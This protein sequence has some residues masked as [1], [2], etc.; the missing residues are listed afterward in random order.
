MKRTRDSRFQI[1]NLKS[2]I[3]HPLRASSRLPFVFLLSVFVS[4]PLAAHAAVKVTEQS[5]VIPTYLAGP[6]DPN[7]MFY[8]GQGSQGAEGRVY[9]Y[10]LYDNLTN[11]KSNKAYR[12]VYLENEYVRIGI[13]PEV[14]GRLFEAVDKSNGYILFTGSMSLNRR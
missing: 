8:F 10:P 12:I 6:P 3:P 14:G 5:I 13:L 11:I 9:P 2:S 4:C 7:P 1:S